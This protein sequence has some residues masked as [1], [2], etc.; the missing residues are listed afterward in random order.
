M[1]LRSSLATFNTDCCPEG[2]LGED[3]FKGIE[4]FQEALV[5]QRFINNCK[6]NPSSTSSR[7]CRGN[8]K[9]GPKWEEFNLLNCSAKSNVTNDL[10]KLSKIKLC[11][12]DNSMGSGCQTPV[13]VSGNL[14]Q[15]I[16]SGKSITTRQDLEYISI[17]LKGL[18]T[19]PTAFSPNNTHNAKEVLYCNDLRRLFV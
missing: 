15:L 17:I 6:Y 19:H 5:S 14:S 18:A 13:E 10:I 4:E 9:D 3:S 12:D 8:L 2:K 16:N 7:H 1:I 11:K